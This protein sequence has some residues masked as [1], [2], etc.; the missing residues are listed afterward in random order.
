MAILRIAAEFEHVAVKRADD[1][2]LADRVLGGTKKH[3]HRVG[4]EIVVEEIPVDDG[5]FG[6]RISKGSLP[7]VLSGGWR[8]NGDRIE[9][10]GRLIPGLTKRRRGVVL[11]SEPVAK[12]IGGMR[13]VVAELVGM[14]APVVP[15]LT[16]QSGE[17]VPEEMLSIV[18]VERVIDDSPEGGRRLVSPAAWSERGERSLVAAMSHSLRVSS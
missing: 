11:G 3:F 2:G 10:D 7:G 17:N 15:F 18:R 8:R 9:V 1:F 14:D 5:H 12:G 6:L 13:T 16:H 4:D